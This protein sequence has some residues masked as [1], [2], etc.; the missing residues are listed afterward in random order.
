MGKVKEKLCQ[1]SAKTFP[2]IYQANF[3]ALE[4]LPHCVWRIVMRNKGQIT[5]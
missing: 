5:N 4:R 3:H 1:N 2:E